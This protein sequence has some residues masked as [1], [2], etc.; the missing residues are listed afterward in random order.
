MRIEASAQLQQGTRDSSYTVLMAGDVRGLARWP[1][2]AAGW[3]FAVH[4]SLL[5]MAAGHKH[6]HVVAVQQDLVEVHLGHLPL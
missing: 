6:C 1:E 3:R 2:L 4:A 5:W